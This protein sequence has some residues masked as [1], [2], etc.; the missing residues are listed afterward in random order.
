[1]F[2][3]ILKFTEIVCLNLIRLRIVQNHQP[4][5]YFRPKIHPIITTRIQAMK[6]MVTMVV[7]WMMIDR[8]MLEW[9]QQL[10]INHTVGG[11]NIPS[12]T[13]MATYV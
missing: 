8:M 6:K 12:K 7:E 3:Q 4:F 9:L 10:P 11:V 13:K 5:N 1:M 2:N